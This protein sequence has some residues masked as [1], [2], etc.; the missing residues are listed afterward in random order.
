MKA[1]LRRT[2]STRLLEDA[3]GRLRGVGIQISQNGLRLVDQLRVVDF[4]L[5]AALVTQSLHPTT[6]LLSLPQLLVDSLL[7]SQ[8]RT[9]P[10]RVPS[11]CMPYR[12]ARLTHCAFS[13]LRNDYLGRVLVLQ[14]DAFLRPFHG[15][16]LEQ[17]A[18]E[19]RIALL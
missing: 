2:G 12:S 8:R 17:L 18:V 7:S 15:I 11:S 16:L 4:L 6:Q 1:I 9:R 10:T 5:A 3:A 19:R 13:K 14:R